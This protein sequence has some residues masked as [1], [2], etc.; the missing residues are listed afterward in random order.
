MMT[1]SAIVTETIGGLPAVSAS[2]MALSI[3]SLTTTSGHQL[4]CSPTRVVRPCWLANSASRGVENT[5]RIA[6]VPRFVPAIVHRARLTAG[7]RVLEE[8]RM[9]V[10]LLGERRGRTEP[11]GDR[12]IYRFCPHHHS[13]QRGRAAAMPA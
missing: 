6:I 1:S 5:L 3:N 11:V 4:A 2:S 9:F 8:L 13:S 12:V 7:K 10:S